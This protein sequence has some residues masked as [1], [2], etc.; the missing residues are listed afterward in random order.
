MSPK[1]FI[2]LFITTLISVIV[3]VYS[4][5]HEP[6]FVINRTG[7]VVFPKLLPA[8][9]NVGKIAVTTNKRAMTMVHENGNWV[10]IESDR[11]LVE[12]SKVKSAILGFSSF[13]YVES[14]TRKKENYI[15]LDLRDP[16]EKEGRGR[17]VEIF[18]KND[19]CITI[20]KR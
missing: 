1:F 9:D 10:M 19:K 6:G 3:A 8:I 17:K 20:Y 15:K 11:Y 16:K 12:G 14:K 13:R 4:I 18:D 5:S 2:I 7:D